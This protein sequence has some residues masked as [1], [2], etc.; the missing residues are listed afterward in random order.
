MFKR[1]TSTDHLSSVNTLSHWGLWWVRSKSHPGYTKCEVHSF[2]PITNSESPINP[3]ACFLEV[4][5]NQ[6]AQLKP[7]WTWDHL[8]LHTNSNS[9]GR[10]WGT[11]EKEQDGNSTCCTLKW[12]IILKILWKNHD[13]SGLEINSALIW[14]RA[15]QLNYNAPHK[16]SIFSADGSKSYQLFFEI[17]QKKNLCHVNA[18]ISVKLQH[19]QYS[20]TN[21]HGFQGL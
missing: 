13:W 17:N 4:G 2:T 12:N 19:S 5:G 14:Y 1:K 15:I 20:T 6:R 16:A 7:K 8:K 3:S 18:G 21:K 11:L 10:S 9:T